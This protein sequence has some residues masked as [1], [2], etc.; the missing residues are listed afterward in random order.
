MTTAAVRKEIDEDR[1]A[2]LLGLTK[3][4]LRQLCKQSGLAAADGSEPRS[5]T[6]QEIYQLCRW[7]ARTAA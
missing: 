5:F 2:I 3:A 1:A 7:V 4:Q 6:Y